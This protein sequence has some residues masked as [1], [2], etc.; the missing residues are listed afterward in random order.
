MMRVGEPL[1]AR[2]ISYWDPY[3][4]VFIV[5][6]H[7]IELK[8]QVLYFLTGIP[9]LGMVGNAQPVLSQ[10]CNIMEFV[11]RHCRPGVRVKGTRISTGDLERLETRAVAAAVLRILGSQTLHHITGGQMMIVESVLSGTYHGWAQ[12][13]L[14][15][16]K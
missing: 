5:Q 4:E 13:M 16:L 6:G 15:S 1:L 11:E 3:H 7:K 10:G 9:P 2:I 12:M 8:V 14:V